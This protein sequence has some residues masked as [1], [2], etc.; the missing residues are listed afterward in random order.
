MY[1]LLFAFPVSVLLALAATA[2][3]WHQCGH[4]AQPTQR[5]WAVLI[6]LGL[7]YLVA[8]ALVCADPYFTDN[9][10]E[11]FIAWPQ[12]WGWALMVASVLQ[13]VL[14]P[15]TLVAQHYLRREMSA[16]QSGR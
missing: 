2:L 11:E 12:R 1:L 8:L 5:C 10:V 3:S 13:W 14:V 7:S 6:G 9:E 16:I 15:I 4:R